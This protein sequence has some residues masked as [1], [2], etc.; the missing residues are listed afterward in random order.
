MSNDGEDLLADIVQQMGAG[1]RKNLLPWWIKIF[2]WI[3]LIFGAL[4]PVGLFSAFLGFN[5]HLSLYGLETMDSFSYTGICI[6]TLFLL[7]GITSYGLLTEADWAIQLG[8]IDAAVGISIC[9]FVMFFSLFNSGSSVF[10][11]RLELVFLIPYLVKLIK[12][13]PG[14]ENMVQN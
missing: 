12:I 10:S 5:F 8:I 14:W 11:F 4:T 9:S 3:F 13:K 6:I 7:K 2:M 1:R